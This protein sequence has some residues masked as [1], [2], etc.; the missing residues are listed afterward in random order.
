ME[1]NDS[2]SMDRSMDEMR[3]YH[4]RYLDAVNSPVRRRIL[5][6]LK[7]GFMTIEALH[8][9][10]GLDPEALKWHLGILEHGFCVK[11]EIRDGKAV[12]NITKE[13]MIID[14]LDK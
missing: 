14:Y 6:D 11:K 9:N 2:T 8:V 4:A 12:Y 13:G 1:G 7:R 5:L 10:T 3:E